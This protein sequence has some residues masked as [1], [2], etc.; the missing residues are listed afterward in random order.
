MDKEIEA[1][2]EWAKNK[3]ASG[4]EPPWAWYQ[5]MKL[6]EALD[7]ILAGQ[8]CVTTA[9]SQQSDQHP[10]TRLRLVESTSPPDSA[11]H[12]P[13]SQPVQMPM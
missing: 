6:L 12:H 5:Y 11:Q 10:G 4:A 13:E 2:R 3:I 1:V 8:S 7:A 9:N